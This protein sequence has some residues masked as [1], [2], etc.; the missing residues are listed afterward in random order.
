MKSI[1]RIVA[2]THITFIEGIRDRA[3]YGITIVALMMLATN[4]LF[5]NLFG[6]ELGKIMVD[7]N[8][9]TISFAGLL[10]TFFV[11]INLM[12][13]DIDRQTIYCVLSKP[14]SRG[15]YIVGKYLGLLSLMI[16]AIFLLTVCSG[17][18]AWFVKNSVADYFFR[19]FSW[20]C[21][22]Q[23]ILYIML[24]FTMLNAVVIFFSSIST[25][26][27][28]TVL[29]SVATYIVG[30]SIEEVAFFFKGEAVTA[31]Y[32]SKFNEFLIDSFQYVVP[33][34]SAFDIKTMASHGKLMS[35]NHTIALI[36]YTVIYSLLL[37]FF[38][39]HIFKR[40]EFN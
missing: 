27:F 16:T 22:A 34:F 2:L 24:M 33:N 3:L 15:E 1:R 18:I 7:L 12:S 38:A 19:T 17:G 20:T 32:S 4:I 10:L 30:Q 26:A 6:H 8:L 36:G 21:Y 23:A 39:S 11:N 9:S 29:F 13:K 31:G 35:M 37:L 14:F 5:T 28:L 40:R 25:S